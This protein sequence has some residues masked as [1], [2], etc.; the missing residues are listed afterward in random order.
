MSFLISLLLLAGVA[1]R[2]HQGDGTDGDSLRSSPDTLEESAA[3]QAS[4]RQ[5]TAS[6]WQP[7]PAGA[8]LRSAA[9]PGWGQV[10]NREPLKGVL[11][12]TAELGLLAWLV[13]EHSLASQARDDYRRTG[14]PA[15]EESY[16]RHSDRRLDLIWYTSAAW[17]YGMLDAYVDAHLY[18][19]ARENEDFLREID[20]GNE[21]VVGGAVF[22]EF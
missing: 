22:I 14:D 3:Q 10:Y 17:L 5:P 12:A 4:V 20:G 9:I 11:L 1:Q 8:L 16:E 13:T 19:F 7:D 2:P 6:P 18:G 15:Y 21:L